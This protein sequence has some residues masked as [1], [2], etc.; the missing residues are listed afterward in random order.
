MDEKRINWGHIIAVCGI[1]A[2]FLC[3]YYSHWLGEKSTQE[4][5]LESLSDHF[6]FV[7]ESMSYEQAMQSLY[8]EMKEKD[9]EIN[10]L[11]QQIGKLQGQD[12]VTVSY[13]NPSLI[14]D[15]LK[16]ED[17]INRAVLTT[18]NHIYYLDSVLSR[19][20][21]NKLIYDSDKD[22]IIYSA[23]GENLP[24]ETKIDLFDTKVL[25]E[26]E[27]FETFIPADGK[28]FAMG[29]GIYNKGFT[30]HH[31][32]YDPNYNSG[33]ALFDL[34]GKYSK[35]TFEVGRLNDCNLQ[36]AVLKVYLNGVYDGEF[37]LDGSLPPVTLTIDLKYANSMK[38]QLTNNDYVGYGF[39]NM[40]LE[41]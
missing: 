40:I 27:N 24:A 20:L 37:S 38:I 14:S 29:S 19:I 25:Y 17:N 33:I 32:S 2:T 1:I 12:T 18:G 34:Q 36:N 10:S 6:D 15:G 3:A 23:N 7:D 41:Y 39:A 4:A 28:T 16:I 8:E 11:N 9:L 22:V 26:G 35:I 30:L 5:I 13:K 21:E 31:K